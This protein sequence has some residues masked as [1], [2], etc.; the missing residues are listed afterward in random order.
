MHVI[1][2]TESKSKKKFRS[3]AEARQARE[4]EESW[5]KIQSKWAT[6]SKTLLKP[7]KETLVVDVSVPVRQTRHIPSKGNGIGVAFAAPQKTYTGTKLKGI[8]QTHKSNLVPVFTDEHITD[9]ARM[10]R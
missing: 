4:L 5:N 2:V 1:K 9:I 8:S 7:K 10:R 6:A 3:A